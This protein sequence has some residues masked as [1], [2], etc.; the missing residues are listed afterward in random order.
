MVWPKKQH[1]YFVIQL[2]KKIFII[3]SFCCCCHNKINFTVT[4]YA[5]FY[6]PL[7][8][9]YFSWTTFT[10]LKVTYMSLWLCVIWL[11]QEKMTG[12]TLSLV[13]HLTNV[14]FKDNMYN[15][16]C[17]AENQAG[18]NEGMVQ[19]DIECKCLRNKAPH[20]W[21]LTSSMQVASLNGGEGE[22]TLGSFCCAGREDGCRKEKCTALISSKCPLYKY[23]YVCTML[24][25][26]L[27]VLCHSNRRLV[28]SG[29]IIWVKGCRYSL[30]FNVGIQ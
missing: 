2:Q 19:L 18:P 21:K 11:L 9:E 6:I 12:S 3:T 29:K 20:S 1:L 15:L 30:A 14:S 28:R 8:Y 22:S 27:S 26:E 10:S 24:L 25:M 23:G 13:L 7:P 16:T 5:Y 17:E 4:K